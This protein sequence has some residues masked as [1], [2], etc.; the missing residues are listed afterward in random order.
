[1]AVKLIRQIDDLEVVMVMIYGPAN[2]RRRAKL[3]GE[4]AE[5]AAPFQGS[6][7][8]MGG[9]RTMQEGRTP[10]QKI[11]GVSYEKRHYKKWGRWIA[12]TYQGARMAVP[13][14][15]TRI[16]FSM[17]NRA[18]RAFSTRRCLITPESIFQILQQL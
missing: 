18:S 17:L 8:L 13:C 3:W 12:Y 10:T 15:L 9:D 14:H 7:V 6:P 16:H 2:V 4:L 1:M 5:M 11:S